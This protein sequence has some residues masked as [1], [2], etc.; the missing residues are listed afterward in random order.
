ML[1]TGKS[2]VINYQ[3][4]QAMHHEGDEGNGVQF[5]LDNCLGQVYFGSDARPKDLNSLVTDG[6]NTAGFRFFQVDSN[7]IEQV[8]IRSDMGNE[9]ICTNRSPEDGLASVYKASEVTL[10]F[11]LPIP[12]PLKLVTK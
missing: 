9:G 3:T 1:S 7:I 10:P 5:L 8:K 11:S 4:G 2:V 6:N 12:A